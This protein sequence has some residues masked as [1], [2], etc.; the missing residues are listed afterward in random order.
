MKIMTAGAAFVDGLNFPPPEGPQPIE[1][2]HAVYAVQTRHW[3]AD[4]SE[5]RTVS[6]RRLVSA[7][8][9]DEA[10]RFVLEH[11]RHP[12]HLNQIVVFAHLHT[13]P[14]AAGDPA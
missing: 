3:L 11:Y 13:V 5:N 14:A 9:A 6:H 1:P 4:G 7:R 8:N 2:N 12:A 10:G